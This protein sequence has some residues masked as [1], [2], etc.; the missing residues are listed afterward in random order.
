MEYKCRF[1]R[2]DKIK[3]DDLKK[4]SLCTE[5]HSF[6]C[7]NPIQNVTISVFGIN[8]T[9]RA[10]VTPNNTYGVQDCEGFSCHSSIEEEDDSED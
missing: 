5:C 1:E 8:K 3:T 9:I 4:I 7:S 10:Y 2:L 6:D